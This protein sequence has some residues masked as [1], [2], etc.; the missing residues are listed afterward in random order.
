MRVV[1]TS[2][3]IEGFIGGKQNPTIRREL[4]PREQCI[5]PTLVQYELAKWSARNLTEEQAA[6]VIAYTTQCTVVDLDTSIALNAAEQALQHNL[7]MAD[8][9]I[10]ATAMQAN[11][12]LLTCD[13]HFEGLERVVYLPKAR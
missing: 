10:Y 13:A 2:A 8:A 1:D 5:V 4:P 11:A 7:A 12:D 9:I 6:A 3:W